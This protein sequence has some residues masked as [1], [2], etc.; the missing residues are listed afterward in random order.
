[1]SENGKRQA[2]PSLTLPGVIINKSW[3][4]I[5]LICERSEY[6]SKFNNEIEEMLKQ[7]YI[8]MID[9]KQISF[10]DD[11]VLNLKQFIRRN[12]SVSNVQWEM[13]ETLPKVLSKNNDSFGNLLDTINYYMTMGR[14][15]LISTH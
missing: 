8:F 4:V 6:M 14:N 9:P 3:N 1:L 12:K 13:F 5:R 7:L 11:I 2:D 10:E 15:E